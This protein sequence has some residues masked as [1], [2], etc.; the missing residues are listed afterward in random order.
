M[1]LKARLHSLAVAALALVTSLAGCADP[2]ASDRA[3]A[4][5]PRLGVQ[6]TPIKAVGARRDV[7]LAADITVSA[8][9]DRTGGAIRIKQTGFSIVF[10]PYAVDNPVTI[11]VTAKAGNLAAYEFQ[12]HGL[13]FNQ[14][15]KITQKLPNIDPS[16]PLGGVFLGYYPDPSTLDQTNGTADVTEVLAAEVGL[17]DNLIRSKIYHFSGYLVATGSWRGG[18]Y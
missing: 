2:T 8:V 10:P 12:P 11:T 17:T 6:S 4:G 9:I 5:L 7:P 18:A 16:S 14:A 1:N 15:V 3:S 13:R